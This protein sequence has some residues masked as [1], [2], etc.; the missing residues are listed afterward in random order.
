MKRHIPSLVVLIMLLSLS[1]NFSLRGQEV[2]PGD[3]DFN[4]RVEHID[5]LY[6]G[7]AFGYEGPPRASIKGDYVGYSMPIDSTWGKKFWNGLDYFYADCNGD[8]LID[9]KDLTV[10]DTLYNKSRATVFF[11]EP[12]KGVAGITP[13]LYIRPSTE[14]ISGG[15]TVEME[16][17]LGD[18]LNNV[19]DFYGLAFDFFYDPEYVDSLD[20]NSFKFTPN[21]WIAGGENPDSVFIHIIKDFPNEGKAEIA[22]SRKDQ[23]MV[24]GQGGIFSF[25]IVIEDIII[26][27]KETTLKYGVDSVFVIDTAFNQ[28]PVEWVS[29]ELINLAMVSSTKDINEAIQPLLQPNPTSGTFTITLPD[30]SEPIERVYLFDQFGRQKPI[31]YHKEHPRQFLINSNG[32]PPGLYLVVAEAS[33]ELYSSKVLISQ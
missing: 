30:A 22:I 29:G 24:D 26:G 4:N 16:F 3:T 12:R 33:S 14:S 15:E 21:T 32:L 18:E 23:K 20:V 10:I 31:Y 8:G 17:F 27:P 28:T 2:W 11:D 6:L 25:S 1:T 5:V 13:P 9:L 7:I 19:L